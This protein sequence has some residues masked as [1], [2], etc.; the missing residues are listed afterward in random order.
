MMETHCDDR[1]TQMTETHCDDRNTLW[2]QKHTVMTETHCDYG[3]IITQ[4]MLL[5]RWTRKGYLVYYDTKV[6]NL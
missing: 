6:S 2:W 5:K 1:N 3:N 4:K